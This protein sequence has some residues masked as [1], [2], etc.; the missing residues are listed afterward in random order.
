MVKIKLNNAIE[1]AL[2]ELDHHSSVAEVQKLAGRYAGKFPEYG[3][4]VKVR[5][6]WRKKN[7]VEGDNRTYANQPRRNMLND[8]TTN[9]QQVQR[10][11]TF[12][13]GQSA[14]RLLW[15]IGADSKTPFHSIEQVVHAV[16]E[17]QSIQSVRRK[18]A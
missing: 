6:R 8:S 2:D 7:K 1:R 17:L 15:L 16:K 3:Y 5:I 4:V 13:E 12:L 14:E 11:N 10:L 9:L 18:A